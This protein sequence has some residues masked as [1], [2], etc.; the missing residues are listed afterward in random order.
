MG[1]EDQLS[2]L[3]YMGKNQE[4]LLPILIPVPL[5]AGKR[6]CRELFEER[7]RDCIKEDEGLETILQR[8]VEGREVIKE[9]ALPWEEGVCITD[10]IAHKFKTIGIHRCIPGVPN[11]SLVQNWNP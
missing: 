5:E 2:A 3:S 9:E 1:S 7:M 10:C 11:M 6:L 4:W 8:Q